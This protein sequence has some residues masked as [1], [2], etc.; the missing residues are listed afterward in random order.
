M[1]APSGDWQCLALRN[2]AL[3][4]RIGVYE[5]E[6]TAPQ[7]ISVDVELWRPGG[8]SP[9][10]SL[11]E[12]LDYDRIYRWL[13]DGWPGRPHVELL[14]TLAEELIAKALEDERVG[15]CRVVIR[16][17]DAYAGVGWPEIELC[18]TRPSSQLQQ[19]IPQLRT[20]RHSRP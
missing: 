14:E 6:K 13:V 8:G 4:V 11:D 9:P 2:V 19:P 15:A 16:K 17:L 3:E 20:D 5:A 7:R 10:R 18:R 1:G 12:C